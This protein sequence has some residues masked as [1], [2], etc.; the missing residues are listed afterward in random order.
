MT[1]KMIPFRS[2]TLTDQQYLLSLLFVVPLGLG[3]GLTTIAQCRNEK[4]RMS[5]KPVRFDRL[6][7]RTLITQ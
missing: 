5:W 7:S 6:N 3:L 2:L 4:Q 1:F